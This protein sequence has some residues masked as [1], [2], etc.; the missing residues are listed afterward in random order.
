M[1]NQLWDITENQ[2]QQQLPPLECK[3][4]FHVTVE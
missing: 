2:S 3:Q 4:T 1:A